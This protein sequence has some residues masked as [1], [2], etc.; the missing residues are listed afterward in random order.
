MTPRFPLELLALPF[1]LVFLAAGGSQVKEEGLVVVLWLLA[2]Q[3]PGLGLSLVVQQQVRV[4][5]T[6]AVGHHHCA[7][8]AGVDVL[9]LEKALDDVD[10]L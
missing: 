2:F 7:D 4:V 8:G 1:L 6:T 10:V 9:D 5:M 3:P